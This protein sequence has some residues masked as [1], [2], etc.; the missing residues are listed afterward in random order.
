[1]FALKEF[2]VR[3]GSPYMFMYICLITFYFFVFVWGY[4]LRGPGENSIRIDADS[5]AYVELSELYESMLVLFSI[6]PNFVGQIFI[7]RATDYNFFIIFL[8]NLGVFLASYKLI[9]DT[10]DVN[11]KLFTALIILNPIMIPVI[12]TLNKEIFGLASVVFYMA[13]LKKGSKRLFFFSLIFALLTRWQMIF[14]VFFFHVFRFI[15][16]SLRLNRALSLLLFLVVISVTY[17]LLFA[18]FANVIDDRT[19]E[20]QQETAGAVINLFNIIQQHYLYVVAVW[21]KVFFNLFGNFFR[22]FSIITNPSATDFQDVYNNVFLLGHQIITFVLTVWMIVKK[23]VDFNN[24]LVYFCCTYLIVFCIGPMIQYRYIF[25]IYILFCVV[26][27]Q[28]APTK[29][30]E[31]I[32]N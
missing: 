3:K 17:P 26:I 11:S 23:K 27:S 21:P 32:Q 28:R 30:R 18:G 13:F 12:T 25:P 31:I 10:F 1:M 6:S 2:K 15:T 7:L 5:F 22:V 19:A 8:I 14:I 16:K 20:R 29:P 4:F 24:D 9:L